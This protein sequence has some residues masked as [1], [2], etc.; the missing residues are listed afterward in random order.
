MR[1]IREGR[2]AGLS[3][4]LR[5][6]AALLR[7]GLGTGSY[8]EAGEL[9]GRESVDWERFERLLTRHRVVA[10]VCRALE[11]LG[12]LVPAAAR[13]RLAGA[14]RAAALR[15]MRLVG[16]LVELARAFE[17]AGARYATLKG[18]AL[19]QLLHG[20]PVARHSGDL[21]LVVAREDFGLAVTALEG[22]G[23]ARQAEP[24]DAVEEGGES[25]A[26]EFGYHGH[27]RRGE[28]MVELH[29]R[30]S[31]VDFAF[32]SS[33]DEVLARRRFVQV[34][35]QAVALLGEEDLADY[36][37]LHGAAHCWGRVKWLYDLGALA[38]AGGLVR[39]RSSVELERI[40][41]WR[42]GLLAEVFGVGEGN[43]G[44]RAG[45]LT[46]L[47]LRQLAEESGEPDRAGNVLRRTGALALC[48][49]GLGRKLDYLVGI[50]AWRA[51]MQR[52]PLGRRWRWLY[53]GIGP[54][55][56]VARRVGLARP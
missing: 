41:G 12:G 36:L 16:D 28:R 24:T 10:P 31:G 20:D 1:D 18:P 9:V 45:A 13:A 2:V 27:Y 7:A 23:Y 3:V 55:Y 33:V 48:A 34:A 30:V 15:Q 39:G 17:G 53:V 6:M 8:E 11:Q 51:C 52:F 32:P 56:W 14:N 49:A 40:R 43:G 37:S 22:L 29:W 50:F 42:D 21:D 35:G 38:G 54:V 26:P 25:G 4:E 46:G 19:S 47:A 5:L 44:L